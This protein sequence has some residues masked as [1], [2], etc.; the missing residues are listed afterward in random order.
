MKKYLLLFED[1]LVAA[2]FAEAGAYDSL[3]TGFCETR[4]DSRKTA[5]LRA[6]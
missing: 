2:T 3:E 5:L 1:L 4:Q 6:S